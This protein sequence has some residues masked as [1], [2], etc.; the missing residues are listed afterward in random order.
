M[1]EEQLRIEYWEDN[2]T[3]R[4]FPL[5][6]IFKFI[7]HASGHSDNLPYLRHSGQDLPTVVKALEGHPSIDALASDLKL[8][9]EELRA[10]LWYCTWLLEHRPPPSAWEEWNNRV[11]EAWKTDTLRITEQRRNEPYGR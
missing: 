4:D 6:V 11:D 2:R 5:W 9:P 3:N 10:V 7:G 8:A 1:D